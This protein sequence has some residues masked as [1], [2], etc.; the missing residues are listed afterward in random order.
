MLKRQQ[1]IEKIPYLDSCELTWIIP[2]ITPNKPMA[3]PKIST[4][5]IFTNNAAFW[6]SAKAAPLPIIPTQIPHAKLENPTVSP[7]PNNL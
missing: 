1:N 2:T 7:A 6:A 3:L 4:I 5:R